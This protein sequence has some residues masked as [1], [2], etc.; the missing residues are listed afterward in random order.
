MDP[1]EGQTQEIRM[2]RRRASRG[3]RGFSAALNRGARRLGFRIRHALD[4][5]FS[6]AS[7][8]LPTSRLLAR[9][10]GSPPYSELPQRGDAAIAALH[11]R[12]W[13]A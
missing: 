5:I 4:R 6:I 8:K 7:R 13:P 11:T 9:V 10:V 3:R 2:R 12:L 1:L